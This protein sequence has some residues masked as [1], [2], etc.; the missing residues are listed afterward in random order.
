[1]ADWLSRPPKTSEP[2][3]ASNESASLQGKSKHIN[4]INHLNRIDLQAIFEHFLLKSELPN[5]LSEKFVKN[6]FLIHDDALYYL[7]K[8]PN[9]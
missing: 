6:N 7:R 4:N 1:M 8:R 5:R 3:H 2:T 9:E